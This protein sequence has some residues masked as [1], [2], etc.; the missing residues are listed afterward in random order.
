MGIDVS[1]LSSTFNQS[2]DSVSVKPIVSPRQ[3]HSIAVLT[4]GE[5]LIAVFNWMKQIN[6]IDNYQA[7]R[8]L[9]YSSE[10]R[11]EVLP[12]AAYQLAESGS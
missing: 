1:S 7:I 4:P 5:C 3:K 11:Y 10:N 6:P 2:V 9:L 12:Q 8:T